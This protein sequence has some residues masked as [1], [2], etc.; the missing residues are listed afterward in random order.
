MS[1]FLRTL[2]LLILAWMLTQASA[3]AQT[4]N[5]IRLMFD[6]SEKPDAVTLSAFDLCIVDANAEVDLEAQQTLGNKML[7]RIN[8]FELS[9]NSPFISAAKAIGIPLREAHSENGVRLDATHPH[10]VT[11]V[12]RKI[13]QRTA[14]RGF[15]GFVIAGLDT[16]SQDAERTACLEAIATIHKTYPDKQLILE[17]GLD[18]VSEARRSLDGVVLINGS[19]EPAHRDQRIRELKRQGVRPLIVDFI[20]DDTPPEEITE[21]TNHLRALGAVPFFT[22]PDLK[23]RHLGPMQEV[24]RDIW[25]LH[26]GS[27]RE[28]FTAK[29]LHGSL[30]WLGYHIH[31][32]D[33]ASLLKSSKIKSLLSA[34]GIILDASYQPD[35]SQQEALLGLAATLKKC[36]IPLLLTTVPWNTQEEFNAWAKL[37]DLSG[38]GQKI[39]LGKQA[40]VIR[41]MDHTWLQESG[42]IRPRSEGFRNLQAPVGSRILSSIKASHVFD[43]VFLTAWGG[44]WLDPLAPAL[45]TQLQPLPFLETW[46]GQQKIAP[47]L[48]TAT[49][50]G[51]RL[52]IPVVSSEGFTAKTSQQGLPLAAEALQERILSRYSF[53]FTV[54]VCEGDVRG[55]MPGLDSRDALRYETAARAI[56]ALPQVHAASSS[57]SRPKAWETCQEMEYEV[58]G[59]MAYIHRQLLPHGKHVG[60][61]LWP[62]EAFP[63]AAAVAFS[64]KMGAENLFTLQQ[65]GL[66]GR[67][68]PPAA[69]TW[70]HQESL[71]TLA[72][73]PRQPGA[74]KATPFIA[75]AESQDR[76]R[77]MSPLH[78]SLTFLDA[79]SDDSLW[80]MERIM[81]WCASQ[82]LHA[83]NAADHAKIVSDAA[84]TRIFEQ[85][86]NHWIIVNSGHARTLRLPTNLGV[87]DLDRS[88]GIAGYTL[89]GGDLYIHTLGRRRTELILTPQGTPDHL[90]LVS[91]SGRVRYLE[92]GYQRALLQ[93]ADLRPVEL[94]FAGITPGA[95]CQIYTTEQP[96]FILADARGCVQITVPAQTTIRIQVMQVPHAAMRADAVPQAASL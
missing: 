86:N 63:T 29:L 33:A 12:V 56:F 57:R 51:R 89:R 14:E 65:P 70:G 78:V 2:P 96:Q 31:Y 69:Q 60:L 79:S 42:A 43:Q 39:S 7:A 46:L 21:R 72:T 87:P 36:G 11:L 53:P 91:S 59:S 73:N 22:T 71:Q 55:V 66:P 34:Q 40:P 81:D 8:I 35:A 17:G 32:Q 41:I 62:S 54:A 75:Q 85:E 38:N 83:M 13:I 50:N 74:L 3:A 68:Y 47:V 45:G 88:I 76:G 27:A 26:A 9:K 61:M 64:R 15:D 18:M 93:V 77:W 52:F 48:D 20:S 94:S 95:L 6:L 90:R 1:P 30:E 58:A 4:R 37:L 44:M 24:I 10:W 82:P 23:G 92:S 80:E 28:S 49:Q 19:N 5:G 84:K 67:P 16:I 25:V